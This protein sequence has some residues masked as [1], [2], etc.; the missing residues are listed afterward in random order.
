ME[1]SDSLPPA[2]LPGLSELRPLAG[3]FG[4]LRA[5]T[6]AGS[7]DR[8]AYTLQANSIRLSQAAISE[9]QLGVLAVK[10]FHEKRQELSA[11][12][13]AVVSVNHFESCLWHLERFLKH[14]RALRG[15]VSAE[16]DLKRIIPRT[17]QIFEQ[18]AESRITRLRHR[19]AHLEKAA[20]NSE[21][22][23]GSS[24]MLRPVRSGLILADIQISWLELAAWLRE[25][26]SIVERLIEFM[27]NEN[28][29]P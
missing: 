6:G 29:V 3:W 28:E 19:L 12:H 22:P 4:V 7:D 16:P 17:L 13:W 5:L 2:D 21:L 26:H 20:Q 27:P 10:N 8:V 15:S 23:Q 11:L 1:F 25:A 9:Y 24:I 14:C 18:D